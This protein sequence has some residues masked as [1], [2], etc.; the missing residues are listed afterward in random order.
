LPLRTVSDTVDVLGGEDT[1][2]VE[3][4]KST[5]LLDDGGWET[6]GIGLVVGQL[7]VDEIIE[8]L[9]FVTI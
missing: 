6:V 8:L 9:L 5:S 2:L 1:L 4:G 3:V 7:R